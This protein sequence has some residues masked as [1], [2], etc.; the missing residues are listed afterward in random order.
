MRTDVAVALL[1]VV[2]LAACWLGYKQGRATGLELARARREAEER[3]PGFVLRALRRRGL[4]PDRALWEEVDRQR[5]L[6]RRLAEASDGEADATAVVKE[7]MEYG[8]G[9]VPPG[10]YRTTDIV[11]DRIHGPTADR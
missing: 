7:F 8:G 4:E 2:G 5:D 3:E 10:T 1:A 11:I 9:L 6:Y